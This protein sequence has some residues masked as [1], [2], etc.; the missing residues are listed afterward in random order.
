M[1]E[2]RAS[3]PAQPEFNVRYFFNF[4]DGTTTLDDEGIELDG[5]AAVKD[6]AL[7]SSTEILKGLES[8]SFWDGQPWLLWVSDQPNGGG[9]TV[10]SLTFTA[11]LAA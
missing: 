1:A 7:K 2:R 3:A 8:G 6:E 11:Q 9:N 10:L 5:M 4:K